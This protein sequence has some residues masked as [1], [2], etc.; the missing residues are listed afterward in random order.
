MRLGFTTANLAFT[1]TNII[2]GLEKTGYWPYNPNKL[3]ARPLLRRR[4]DIETILDANG[5]K[6]LLERN[7]SSMYW[8]DSTCRRHSQSYVDTQY[9]SIPT[10]NA[11]IAVEKQIKKCKTMKKLIDAQK[12][13]RKSCKLY[14]KPRK[15]AVFVAE[16]SGFFLGAF[17]LQWTFD[18]LNAIPRRMKYRRALARKD[19]V[20]KNL[21]EALRVYISSGEGLVGC[22]Q[23]SPEGCGV[24]SG[25]VT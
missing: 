15:S 3:L 6:G 8:E 16:V 5:L 9:G 11:A 12:N 19:K 23:S 20:E 25:V 17:P 1:L 21:Q 24:M 14:A 10:S 2:R 13:Q 7:A 22:A 4:D 18:R